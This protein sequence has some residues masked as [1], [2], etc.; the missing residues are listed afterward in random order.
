MYRKL[1]EFV[2]LAIRRWNKIQIIKISLCF[3]VTATY[4]FRDSLD[5]E[6]PALELEYCRDNCS[7]MARAA[8]SKMLAR[9]VPE[10]YKPVT[11]EKLKLQLIKS[12][13][14]YG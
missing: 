2:K 13:I 10:N 14:V 5:G 9:H 3:K 12:G 8:N 11:F 4:L 1:V 6:T 7:T